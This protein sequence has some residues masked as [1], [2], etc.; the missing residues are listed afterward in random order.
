[1]NKFLVLAMTVIFLFHHGHSDA[2]CTTIIDLVSS[3]GGSTDSALIEAK[4]RLGEERIQAQGGGKLRRLSS[5]LPI[6][7]YNTIDVLGTKE[8]PEGKKEHASIAILTV[9]PCSS[10]NTYNLVLESRT[11]K[12]NEVNAMWESK[13]YINP[14]D[15]ATASLQYSQALGTALARYK[16]NPNSKHQYDLISTY[17]ALRAFHNLNSLT[18]YRLVFD[19]E[20]LKI[21]NWYRKLRS[22]VSHSSLTAIKNDGVSVANEEHAL[23]GLYRE[24]WNKL[25]TGGSTDNLTA[26]IRFRESIL[27]EPA[28]KQILA[29]LK[30]TEEELILSINNAIGQA[31]RSKTSGPPDFEKLA[32]SHIIQASAY[33]KQLE[34]T[35]RAYLEQ[36]LSYLRATIK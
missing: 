23:V 6:R 29:Q 27:S 35:K 26:M 8:F 36:E 1:M 13:D 20:I 12:A 17:I 16:A 25:T 30:L 24:E 19:E 4:S 31:L 2:K 21:A 11:G 15:I 9:W 33:A 14:S 10:E 18:G 22:E 3:S 5:P 7:L 32:S 28:K 34:G